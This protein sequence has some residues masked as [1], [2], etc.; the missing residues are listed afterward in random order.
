MDLNQIPRHLGVKLAR[1][2][3]GIVKFLA[4]GFQINVIVILMV[5]HKGL[6][7]ERAGANFLCPLNKLSHCKGI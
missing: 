5:H 6:H 3:H 7:V 1:L 4:L 2:L